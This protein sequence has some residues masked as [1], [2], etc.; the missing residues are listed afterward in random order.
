LV[1]PASA[2]VRDGDQLQVTIYNAPDLSRKV[3]VDGAGAISIP[4]AGTV[5]VRGLEPGQAARRIARALDPYFATRASVG[6]ET[7]A[8]VDSLFVSGGPG[9]VLKYQPGETLLAALA[10]LPAD[11]ASPATNVQKSTG[12]DTLARSR[13]DLHRV[14][15]TRDGATIGTYD[16]IALSERGQSGPSLQAGDTICL[17]DKP[18]VVR[19]IG[20]VVDPGPAYLATDESL[21]DAIAQ[22]GGV[23]D[24]AASANIRLQRNGTTQLITLG[25]A[26]LN[27]PA[28][29]GDVITI[30]TA[31]RVSVAGTVNK[32]GLVT[33]KNN[34]TLLDALYEAG[35]PARRADLGNV[36]V[37]HGGAPVTYNVADLAHGNLK[38]NPVLADGDLVMVPERRGVDFSDVF[39]TLVPFIYLVPKF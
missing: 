31:P 3:T 33:L 5:L 26:T 11:I 13:V 25:S 27:E 32:P 39:Q 28:Q 22:A 18:V 23:R 7:I 2:A 35:G 29:T 12:F 9:G 10:D 14:S 21:D 16:A 30:P 1:V 17:A 19:V 15:V 37:I 8:Q 34:F 6:V 36:E 24:S 4:L 20:D 38:Q